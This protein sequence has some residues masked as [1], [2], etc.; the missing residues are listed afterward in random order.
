MFSVLLFL[1]INYKLS[2]RACQKYVSSELCSTIKYLSPKVIFR[3]FFVSRDMF[4]GDFEHDISPEYK[5]TY[6][7][8]S[9]EFNQC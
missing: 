5:D 1:N 9:T 2:H 8:A 3:V 7:D 6:R 4:C